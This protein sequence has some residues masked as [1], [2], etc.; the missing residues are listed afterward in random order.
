M[1][2]ISNTFVINLKHSTTRMK[3][4]DD[5]MKALKIPYT[6]WDATYGK[7][8]PRTPDNV[9]A[10]CKYMLCTNGIIGCYKS[11]LAIW[12]HIIQTY[13]S[14]WFLVLE[15][16]AKL[17][18][19]SLD[20]IKNVF[21]DLANWKYAAPFPEMI[22]LSCEGVCNMR[23]VTL[24]L[25]ENPIVHGTT[26]YIISYQGAKKLVTLMDK[27]IIYHVDFSLTIKQ[28]ISKNIAYYT[29]HN[30]IQ[31]LDEESTISSK[32]FP[33]IESRILAKLLPMFNKTIF[34]S[35]AINVGKF[36]INLSVIVLLILLA[37]L[38]KY[39]YYKVAVVYLIL[40]LVILM[41]L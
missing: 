33:I 25:Y 10:L 2:N 35:C 38:L 12:K 16:D 11:H 21:S 6:R 39:R 32:S 14:G 3:R 24:N 23:K 19:K 29:T 26:A 37:V 7:D 34:E 15:D 5:N 1:Q 27:P 9:S 41:L 20:N 8:V 4:F 22:S 18:Q 40:E 30:Y 28:L 13:N 31:Q 17:T 36:C